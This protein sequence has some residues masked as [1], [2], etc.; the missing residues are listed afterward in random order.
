MPASRYA[1]APV[2]SSASGAA[3]VVT[4]EDGETCHGWRN[5]SR[6]H[7]MSS[8][9]KTT[10]RARGAPSRSRVGSH[11][12][13]ATSAATWANH[14]ARLAS[15]HSTMSG[16]LDLSGQILEFLPGQSAV[17]DELHE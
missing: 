17:L 14:A 2:T 4:V 13:A 1:S 11:T 7:A 6:T 10:R 5:G 3:S 12:P 15:D 9:R 16:L 8:A